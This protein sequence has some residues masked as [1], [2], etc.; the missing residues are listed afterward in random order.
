MKDVTLIIIGTG[1]KGINEA[2][3]SI[4]FD[5]KIIWKGK[6]YNGKVSCKLKKGCFYKVSATTKYGS[7]NR[8]FYVNNDNTYIFTFYYCTQNISPISRLITFKLTDYY[9]NLEISRGK[10]NFEQTS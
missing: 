6:T 3:V 5:N 9:Y 2:N 10:L 1:Y 4:Y 8:F 7:L